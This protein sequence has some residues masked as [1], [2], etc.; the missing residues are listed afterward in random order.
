[1]FF[2]G[3]INRNINSNNNSLIKYKTINTYYFNN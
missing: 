3:I 2:N 1:M